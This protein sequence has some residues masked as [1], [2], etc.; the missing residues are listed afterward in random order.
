MRKRIFLITLS[1]G[2]Y[3]GSLSYSW[4]AVNPKGVSSYLQGIL[5]IKDGNYESAYRHLQ[6]AKKLDPESGHIRFKLASVLLKL[7]EFDKA[8]AELQAAKELMA[9][10]LEPS[11]ALIFLYS[12]QQSDKKLETEYQF[13]LEKAHQLRPENIRISEYLGQFYFYKKM[14]QEAIKI[15]KTVISQKP[16][17]TEGY[18]WLGYL[19]EEDGQRKKAISLWRKAL[20]IDPE[21]RDTLN[22]LGYIYAEEGKKLNEA[23]RL[24]RKAL[25]KDPQNG[26]YLDS[27]GWVYYK[28]QEYEKAEKYLLNA[29]Q[30]LEEPIVYEHLGEVYLKL[31]QKEKALYY[32][33]KGNSLYPEDEALQQKLQE[34]AE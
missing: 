8:E 26:A 22:S 10:S 14:P 30:Y 28:R 3:L 19:Y 25:E 13:F 12:S 34:Y 5:S 1:L 2:L 20:E 33:K 29:L 21:H 31:D 15:Y 17:Y 27:L 23:E 7:K 9:D 11:V 6:R 24:V 4:A 32:Y 16:D 18:F